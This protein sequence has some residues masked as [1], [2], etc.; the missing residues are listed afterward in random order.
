MTADPRI[1][2]VFFDIDGTLLS[3]NTPQ[4]ISINSICSTLQET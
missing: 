3:K 1:R 2:A 4:I